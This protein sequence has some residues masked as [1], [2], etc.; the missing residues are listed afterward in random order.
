MKVYKCVLCEKRWNT[1][2][3]I[4]THVKNAH[5]R[6]EVNKK[7]Y[8]CENIKISNVNANQIA[9]TSNISVPKFNPP[10]RSI[11]KQIGGNLGSNTGRI[12]DKTSSLVNTGSIQMPEESDITK[13]KKERVN[14]AGS[15]HGIKREPNPA[16][17]KSCDDIIKKL[18]SK[19]IGKNPTNKQTGI[20]SLESIQK[21]E[22]CDIT[23]VKKEL[24]N[25]HLNVASSSHGIN[26]EATSRNETNLAT[27]KISGGVVQKLPPKQ[28]GR[29]IE[30]NPKQKRPV[31]ESKKKKEQTFDYFKGYTK[32]DL[33]VPGLFSL[34]STANSKA[35][36]NIEK[37]PKK[38]IS[39]PQ[40]NLESSM[41]PK[42]LPMSIS[43]ST[44]E[45]KPIKSG[46]SKLKKPIKSVLAER[47][48]IKSKTLA[49]ISAG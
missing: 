35:K 14:V 27:K 41:K 43:K 7:D 22:E 13:V 48:V 12:P 17:K 23:K 45:I 10:G 5:S 2:T 15:S 38:T 44:S 30:K 16:I 21:P 3:G 42:E 9:P 24:I 40:L 49:Q 6:S 37:N 47:N 20:I 1:V 32:G 28:V 34:V 46:P 18:L 8:I 25:E 29:K 31:N 19:N 36:S 4:E 33:E 26:T 39:I 11:N